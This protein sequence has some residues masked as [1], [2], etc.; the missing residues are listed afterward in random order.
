MY[1]EIVQFTKQ[2]DKAREMYE[3]V[4]VSERQEAARLD[5]VEPNVARLREEC[6]F[7]GLFASDGVVAAAAGGG[8]GSGMIPTNPSE[9]ENTAST[10][11]VGSAAFAE[12]AGPPLPTSKK[13]RSKHT[14]RARQ[15]ST[16]GVLK[17]A[18]DN[19]GTHHHRRSAKSTK[20]SHPESSSFTTKA[21]PVAAAA[22]DGSRA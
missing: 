3:A 7:A 8:G 17:E 2:S 15:D 6:R 5:Q 21:A 1:T 4:L 14:K 16:S 18:S 10:G 20:V 9:S 11:A 22:T 13:Q 19:N 12:G